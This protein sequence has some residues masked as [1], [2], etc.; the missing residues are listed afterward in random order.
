MYYLW[1][2]LYC[3]FLNLIYSQRGSCV[4][5]GNNKHPHRHALIFKVDVKVGSTIEY[6]FGT[7]SKT[8]MWEGS[9]TRNGI[10]N[11]W[12]MEWEIWYMTAMSK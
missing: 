3:S 1:A 10:W 11:Q 4:G 2:L 8:V 6:C 5:S 7:D 9:L 12:F